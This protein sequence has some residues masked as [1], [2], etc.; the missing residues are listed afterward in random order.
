MEKIIMA[1][2]YGKTYQLIKRS[3]QDGGTIICCSR[4]EAR[5]IKQMAKEMNLVILEPIT[6]GDIKSKSYLGRRIDD[7]YLDNV[8]LFIDYFS[9]V[10]VRIITLNP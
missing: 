4:N 5:N 7:Y 6:Y 8:E 9:E 3:A 2:G 10:P 1:R